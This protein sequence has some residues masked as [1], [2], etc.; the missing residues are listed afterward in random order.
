MKKRKAW[1]WWLAFIALFLLSQDYLFVQWSNG[2]S[3]LGFPTWM[4][5]FMLLHLGFILVFY[6]FAKKYWE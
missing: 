4:S 5:W 2:T 3:W 6:L 1:Y